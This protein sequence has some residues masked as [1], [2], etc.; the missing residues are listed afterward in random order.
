MT[1]TAPRGTSFRC[2]GLAALEFAL[3]LPLLVFLVLMVFD[4]SR[5]LLAQVVLINITR[6]GA[7]LA[8]RTPAYTMPVLMDSLGLTVP[9]PP[10][11]MA[12]RGMIYITEITAVQVAGG[13]IQHQVTAQTRWTRGS[14]FRFPSATGYTCAAWRADGTCNLPATKPVVNVMSGQLR[15]GQT[16]YA[17]E[18]FYDFN[19]L[20]GQIDLGFGIR[21]PRIGPD[22]SAMT[23]M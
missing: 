8:S 7:S 5:G 20:F 23:V 1:A 9:E 22:L 2:A 3:L 19:M 18:A 11:D 13:A 15:S 12:A 21:T 14:S 16:I 4:F 17:A 10:M 6:E